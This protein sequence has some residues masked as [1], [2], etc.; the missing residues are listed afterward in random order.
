VLNNVGNVLTS[1]TVSSGLLSEQIN[2]SRAPVLGRVAKLMG[3][4]RDN[5][6]TFMSKDPRGKQIPE[7]IETL[8]GELE[9]ERQLNLKELDWL[10][11]HIGHI[12]DIVTLQQSFAGAAA[13]IESVVLT[14]LVEDALRISG[15]VPE[16][17][18]VKLIR[19]YDDLFG[20]CQIEKHV[21]LQILVNL[22]TNAMQ[23]LSDSVPGVKRSLAVRVKRAEGDRVRIAVSDSGKGISPEQ[24][25]LIFTFGFTTRPGGHGFGLH[26]CAV[27]AK[28]MGA[29]LEVHSD[30]LGKGATFTLSLPRNATGH[31]VEREA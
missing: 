24:M 20:P 16:R 13:L 4:Q 28:S 3:E 6:G 12:R 29:D 17:D 22:L 11:Q 8:A 21:V 18:E 9:K 10:Q 1:V 7:F 30:G 14:D 23:A 15:V 2:N 25:P 19:D 26:S 5:I 31:G 27:N